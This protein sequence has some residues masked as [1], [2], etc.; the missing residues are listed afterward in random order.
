MKVKTKHNIFRKI[1]VPKGTVIDDLP[2]GDFDPDVMVE[3]ESDPVADV[4]VA[5]VPVADDPVADVPV[6]EDPFREKRKYT[7][8]K[9]VE[10]GE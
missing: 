2:A 4:P 3:L 1:L 8:R 7:R 10:E 6:A 9:R 5:D